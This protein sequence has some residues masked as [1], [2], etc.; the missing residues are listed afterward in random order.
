MARQVKA[1]GELP[2]EAYI[3]NMLRKIMGKKKL[4]PNSAGMKCEGR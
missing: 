2:Q 4:K 1:E 3:I